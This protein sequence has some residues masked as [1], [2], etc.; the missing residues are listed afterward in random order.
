MKPSIYGLIR[1]V[2]SESQEKVAADKAAELDQGVEKT[3][4]PAP[5]PEPAEEPQSF[6]K[7]AETKRYRSILLV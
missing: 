7:I 1:Q 6:L 5:V 2:L 4:E 3:A